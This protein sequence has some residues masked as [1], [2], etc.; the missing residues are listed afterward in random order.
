L[1]NADFARLRIRV[2]G[3]KHLGVEH[4][5]ENGVAVDPGAMVISKL[6]GFLRQ[7]VLEVPSMDRRPGKECG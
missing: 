5:V 4:G 2:T 6:G 1:L 3:G 7:E